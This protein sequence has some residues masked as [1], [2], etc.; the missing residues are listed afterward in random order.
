VNDEWVRGGGTKIQRLSAQTKMSDA[1]EIPHP[2][3][4]RLF[5]AC[6]SGGP[7]MK[8]L[9]L[10]HMAAECEIVCGY[11]ATSRLPGQ[12]LPQL[13]DVVCI[14]ATAFRRSLA[15]PQ[16]VVL[17]LT[18]FR[19]CDLGTGF[20]EVASVS[21]ARACSAVTD[22]FSVA[23][24]VPLAVVEA[25]MQCALSATGTC[26]WFSERAAVALCGELALLSTEAWSEQSAKIALNWVITAC[27]VAERRENSPARETLARAAF[28]VA[29]AAAARFS[30][31]E[32]KAKEALFAGT[33]LLGSGGVPAALSVARGVQPSDGGVMGLFV[34]TTLWFVSRLE[35]VDFAE[36]VL[37]VPVEALAPHMLTTG[38]KALRYLLLI[39]HES[40]RLREP[41]HV[42][43]FA[44][45]DALGKAACA[46]KLS[47]DVMAAVFAPHI[48]D[49]PC[50]ALRSCV[51]LMGCLL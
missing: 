45:L 19:N 50:L 9:Q 42:N 39:F 16:A 34:L 10:A 36:V 37:C 32:N 3:L 5:H 22:L 14:A 38:L 47:R 33:F 21:R 1:T 7:R 41:V 26:S 8:K 23:L 13:A 15:S 28:V 48:T 25:A 31:C 29:V 18:C 11:I 35:P 30:E 40:V 27:R 46:A 4:A 17:A 51:H 43:V 12:W 49:T 44:A 2:R 24:P 20:C 6:A